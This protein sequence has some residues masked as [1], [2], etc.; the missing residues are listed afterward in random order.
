VIIDKSKKRLF[1][2]QKQILL[3]SQDI[4]GQN[5]DEAQSGG[6]GIYQLEK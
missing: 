5:E 6:A 1:V 4:E 2:Y 3:F